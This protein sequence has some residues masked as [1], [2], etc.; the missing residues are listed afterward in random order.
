MGDLLSGLVVLFWYGVMLGIPALYIWLTIMVASNRDHFDDPK[1]P[2]PSIR[3]HS[4]GT[5]NDP[6]CSPKLAR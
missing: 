3:R 4:L 5:L 2:E 6:P 1:S